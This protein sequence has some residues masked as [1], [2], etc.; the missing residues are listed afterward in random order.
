MD[1]TVTIMAGGIRVLCLLLFEQTLLSLCDMGW[2]AAG[3]EASTRPWMMH[4]GS[5]TYHGLSQRMDIDRGC[6]S[7]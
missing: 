6:A 4:T 3:I 1:I 7:I 2:L 5:I